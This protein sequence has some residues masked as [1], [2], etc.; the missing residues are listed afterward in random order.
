M[1]P[2]EP[3]ASRASQRE[4]NDEM[5]PSGASPRSSETES[6]TR[7]KRDASGAAFGS[8]K[9]GAQ[10]RQRCP[11]DGGQ[12]SYHAPQKRQRDSDAWNPTQRGS[13]AASAALQDAN[14]VGL[15]RLATAGMLVKWD[16]LQTND[17]FNAPQ[18][19]CERVQSLRQRVQ[20]RKLKIA[21]ERQ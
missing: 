20:L 21:T 15:R 13:M 4:R 17:L 3:D 1:E 10:A 16:V 14:Q 6:E 12:Q 7:P 5:G 19:C 11:S 9:T 2:S 18:V 8:P